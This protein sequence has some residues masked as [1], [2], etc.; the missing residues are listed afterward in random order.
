MKAGQHNA[1]KPETTGQAPSSLAPDH[2]ASAKPDSATTGQAPAAG[3]GTKGMEKGTNQTDT[4][5]GNPHANNARAKDSKAHEGNAT[6]ANGNGN[7]SGPTNAANEPDKNSRP[8]TT[9]GQGAAGARANLTTEQ[10]SKIT[11]VIKKQKV[12]PVKLDIEVRVGTRI[13][14][15]VRYYPLPAE[16]VTIYPQWRGFDYIV[17]GDTI[18]V[19]DPGTREIVAVLDA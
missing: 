7:R 4:Q 1:G 5:S 18:I 6:D 9:T 13:P 12:E 15:H 3:G 19:I 11:T 14:Q 2:G 10:R 8:A 16:V 17:V